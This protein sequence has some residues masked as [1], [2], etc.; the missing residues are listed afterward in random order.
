MK[1]EDKVFGPVEIQEPVLKEL[2]QCHALQRLKKIS[3]AGYFEVYFPGTHHSRFEHSI[4]E[5]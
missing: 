3:Q 5:V 1:I 2:V 4:R